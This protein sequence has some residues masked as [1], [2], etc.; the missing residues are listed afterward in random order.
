ME[1]GECFPGVNLA[2]KKQGQVINLL[3]GAWASNSAATT[4][5]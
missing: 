2:K 3:K 1:D 5:P 4:P